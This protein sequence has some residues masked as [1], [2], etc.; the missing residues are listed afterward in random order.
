M[1]VETRKTI[2]GTE[3]WDNEKKKSL[4]VPIS[5]DLGFEITVNPGSM[6]VGVGVAGGSDTTVVSEVPVLSNMTVKELR[7]YAYEL[8]IEIS[9][10]VRRKEDIIELLS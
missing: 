8:G 9:A 1:I 5:E 3:Y 10:D 7:E 4:F 2:A 6:L